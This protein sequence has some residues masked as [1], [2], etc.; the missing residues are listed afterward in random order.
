MLTPKRTWAI[1]DHLCRAC[2]GRILR[3]VTGN[4]MTTGGNPIY[5]CSD[6]GRSCM[7]MSP[8]ELCWCGFAHKG[9]LSGAYCCISFNILKD[10]P[11]FIELFQACGCDP[12]R[13]TSEVGIVALDML[14]TYEKKKNEQI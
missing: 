10:D 2:G 5:R 4:G 3:C 9:Q 11:G 7:A 1:E 12:E 13:K 6:C 8:D 14:R